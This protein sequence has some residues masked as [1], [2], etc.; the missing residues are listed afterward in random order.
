MLDVHLNRL[1]L[2][3]YR[4][5]TIR[6]KRRMFGHLIDFLDPL[7]LE[8][9][10]RND[11]E[12]WLSRPDLKPATRKAYRSHVR[13]YFRW[14]V[15]EGLRE[16]DPSYRIPAVRVPRGMP[17]PI[18]SDD[19]ALA[20]AVAPP[21]MRAWLLLMCL[22]GFRCCEVSRFRPVDVVQTPTGTMLFIREAKGGGQQSV[23]AVQP[24]LEQLSRLPI[25]NGLWWEVRPHQVT[26]DVSAFLRS[27]G[28]AATAHRLRHWAGTS[29]YGVDQDILATQRL[30]RHVD[31]GTTQIY[32]DINP[33]RPAEVAAL[34]ML[35]RPAE[36]AL[37]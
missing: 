29:W 9:A 21:R 20:L 4:D 32:A 34:V 19:L 30:L 2:A 11:L 24:I 27:I 13:A 25:R 8:Q 36:P 5:E 1:R 37:Y 12:R 6:T 28:I 16:D 23:P 7:P 22:G 17:R 3:G 18:Q 15:E 26:I 33:T 31:V 14:L 35:P 10:S